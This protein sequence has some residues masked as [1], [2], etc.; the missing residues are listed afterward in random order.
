[1]DRRRK[2]GGGGAA[3]G[4]MAPAKS[5]MPKINTLAVVLVAVLIMTVTWAFYAFFAREVTHWMEGKH[6]WFHDYEPWSLVGFICSFILATSLF[7]PA[8]PFVVATGYLFGFHFL[9]ILFTIAVYTLAAFLMFNGA[10][11]WFRPLA[12]G[13][14]REHRVVNGVSHYVKD[15]AEGAKLNLLF[16]FTPIAFAVHCYVMGVTEIDEFVFMLTFLL[17]QSPHILFGLLT[18]SALLAA[19]TTGALD[20]FKIGLLVM[21]VVGT[22]AAMVYLMGVAESV[23]HDMEH[24][25]AS[26]SLLGGAGGASDEE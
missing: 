24:S 5:S 21:G 19:D 9:T 13:W 15:P 10:R 18:G 11:F 20:S 22:F 12:E 8:Q 6:H 4:S 14:L 25:S 17:G 7:L 1:M 26:D 3:V 16:S 23:L 2:R